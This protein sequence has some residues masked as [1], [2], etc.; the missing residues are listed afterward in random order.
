MPHA[1]RAENA[2]S[3]RV[4]GY[5]FRQELEGDETAKLGVL[6]LVDDAHAA[7][8]ELL[9]DAIMGNRLPFGMGGSGHWLD[10]L[11]VSEGKVNVQW[12]QCYCINRSGQGSSHEVRAYRRCFVCAL[13]W[14]RRPAAYPSRAAG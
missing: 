4:F 3:L 13:T 10:M 6:G 11:G 9:D 7:P 14:R 2:P 12:H 1:L 8:A 5:V